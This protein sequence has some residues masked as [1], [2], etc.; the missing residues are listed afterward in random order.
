[1]TRLG[2][3][4]NI[5]AVAAKLRNRQTAVVLFFFLLVPVL[6]LTA[7]MNKELNVGGLVLVFLLFVGCVLFVQANELPAFYRLIFWVFIFGFLLNT[8]YELLHSTLYTHFTQPGY[9]YPEL[10]YMLLESAAG[11]GF[12]SLNLLFA[13]TIFRRGEWRWALPWPRKNVLFVTILAIGIQIAVEVI[14]L[15]SGAWAYNAAMPIIPVLD[16]GLTPTIQMP[17]LILPTFWL[18]QRVARSPREAE[19]HSPSKES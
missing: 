4:L 6:A 17:L 2:S 15:R 8:W 11:D 19:A 18:A 12:I 1:M 10:V 7:G 16:V 14:S 13:V 9:T 3:L 5:H